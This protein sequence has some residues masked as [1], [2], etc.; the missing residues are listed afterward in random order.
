MPQTFYE[1]FLDEYKMRVASSNLQS[2][3][4]DDDWEELTVYFRSGGVYRYDNVPDDVVDEMKFAESR[5]RYFYRYIRNNPD[6]PFTVLRHARKG[7]RHAFN[8][9]KTS[10]PSRHLLKTFRSA[11]WLK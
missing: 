10:E 5:G 11:P 8:I 1:W 3:D 4:Y 7:Y 6:Y 2:F 9:A